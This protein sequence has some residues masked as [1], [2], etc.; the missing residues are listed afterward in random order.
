MVHIRHVFDINVYAFTYSSSIR[1][2]VRDLFE[3]LLHLIW[4]LH[5]KRI[6][7]ELESVRVIQRGSSL[8]TQ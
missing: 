2:S 5:V 4:R 6:I 3:K 7:F 1:N 8:N